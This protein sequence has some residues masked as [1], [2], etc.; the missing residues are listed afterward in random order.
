[1]DEKLTKPQARMLVKI[2]KTNGG[3]VSAYDLNHSVMRRLEDKDLIQGKLSRPSVAVHTRAGLEL[4]RILLK[5][6]PGW[7]N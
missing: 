1:M 4:A 3:G 7:F 2:V 5:N 6:N